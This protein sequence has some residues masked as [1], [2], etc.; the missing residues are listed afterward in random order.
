MYFNYSSKP[1][2][3]KIL[4]LNASLDKNI[5]LGLFL[6]AFNGKKVIIKN[7]HKHHNYLRTYGAKRLKYSIQ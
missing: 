7:F 5:Y 3:A 4:Q 1:R 2:I 6:F